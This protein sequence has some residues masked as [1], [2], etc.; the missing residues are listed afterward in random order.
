M[1]IKVLFIEHDSDTINDYMSLLEVKLGLDVKLLK[2][3]SVDSLTSAL[4]DFYDLIITDVYFNH[5]PETTKQS[6]GDYKLDEIVRAIRNVDKN[7]IIIVNT[8]YNDY[9][10]TTGVLDS[11]N[12]VFDKNLS[13]DLFVWQVKQILKYK[14]N[15]NLLDNILISNILTLINNDSSLIWSVEIKSM[16]EKYREGKNEH[17]QIKSIE[18]DLMNLLNKCG[19]TGGNKELI[20][21]ISKQ[22]IFNIAGN[23]NKFGHLRHVINVFWFGYFLIN[24]NWKIAKD[25]GKEL[26]SEEAEQERLLL[27][28]KSWF[29]ASVFHDIGH[30]GEHLE[31]LISAINVTL[32]VYDTNKTKTVSSDFMIEK[33][34]FLSETI[35][36]T[37][38][39]KDEHEKLNALMGKFYESKKP[40]H[41]M[42]SA[43]TVNN[44]L[45]SP[46]VTKDFLPPALQAIALHNIFQKDKEI[47]SSN[48][49]KTLPL[50]KLL[51]LCDLIEVWDRETGFES[52]YQS[53]VEKLSLSKIT[54]NDDKLEVIINFQLFKHVNDD[55]TISIAE[56][57]INKKLDTVVIPLFEKMNWP[58]L[59]EKFR[60]KYVFNNNLDREIH[61]WPLT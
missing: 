5:K 32:S 29:I 26:F 42:L 6:R 30:L 24:S 52:I 4:H 41:G 1:K 25:I 18:N 10:E 58:D 3:Y 46:L 34:V 56:S 35:I 47:L 7:V 40:D 17:D 45:E 11:V 19:F 8:Q 16:V 61:T 22:E 21:H 49:F 60:I 50:T 55:T 12:Y 20:N 51:I 23:P 28:N 13:Q 15:N 33:N 27:L 59:K 37:L 38:A 53:Y 48:I 14:I 31:D 2:D 57:E 43:I 9:L 39:D 36:N 44:H 54:L